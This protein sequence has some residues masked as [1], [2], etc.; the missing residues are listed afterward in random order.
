MHSRIQVVIL[1]GGR[2]ERLRPLTDR[3]P[4]PLL[5]VC[6]MPILE[7]TLQAVSD[8][9]HEVLI[10]VGYK[11]EKIW[12]HLGDEY[13]GIPLRYIE[14][15]ELGG[16]AHALSQAQ[17]ALDNRFMVLMGDDLYAA[18]DLKKLLEHPWAVLVKEVK[19]PKNFGIVR[20]DR[21]GYLKD[22]IEKPKHPPSRLANCAVYVMGREYFAYEPVRISS[23][24]TGL[25]QT[26][27]KVAQSGISIKVVR[28][29]FW[30]PI[31]YPADLQSAQKL[32]KVSKK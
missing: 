30:H 4:K 22:I 20:R 19:R 13:K 3:R 18:Q 28:A 2:G 24:E 26:L 23:G 27:V 8:F 1:A 10:V 21:R 25:P 9:A 5:H 16:T 15:K 11:G 17:H 32:L 14:Q 31:G 7:W 6:G 29:T 12:K